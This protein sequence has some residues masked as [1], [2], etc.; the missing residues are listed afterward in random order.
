MAALAVAED[1]VDEDEVALVVDVDVNMQ[2]D[3]GE[4]GNEDGDEDCL[5]VGKCE[6]QQGDNAGVKGVN[7]CE[8]ER[9]QIGSGN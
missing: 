5:A 1:E 8:R 2:A 4:D 3:V 9:E 7:E 6:Q